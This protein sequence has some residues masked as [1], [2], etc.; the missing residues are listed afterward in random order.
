M[1]GLQST[2]MAVSNGLRSIADSK[3]LTYGIFMGKRF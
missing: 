3:M 2:L 1:A